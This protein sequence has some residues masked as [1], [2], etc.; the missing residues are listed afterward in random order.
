MKRIY[1]WSLLC[2]VVLWSGCQAPAG[3]PPALEQKAGVD[4]ISAHPNA[5]LYP[6]MIYSPP[7]PLEYRVELPRGAVAYLVPSNELPLISLKMIFREKGW[8]AERNEI[9]AYA[10]L[11]GLMRRGGA[12]SL[13]PSAVEDSLEQYAVSAGLSVGDHSSSLTLD[14]LDDVFEQF[15][16]L[17]QS[18]ALTPRLDSTELEQMRTRSLQAIAHRYDRPATASSDLY[19]AVMYGVSSPAIWSAESEEVTRVTRKEIAQLALNR[20]RPEQLVIGVAGRFDRTAMVELLSRWIEQWPVQE[21]AV[22]ELSLPAPRLYPGVHLLDFDSEQA[23]I[24]MGQPFIQR[25]HPDYYASSIA[26]YILGSGGFT[27]RL[28]AAVRSREGLAYSVGSFVESSY[29]NPVTS[30]VSLQTKVES[31]GDAI[32]LIFEEIRRLTEEGPTPEELTKAVEGLIGSLPSLF[33]SPE[34][35]AYALL[36]N[37]LWQRSL[38]HYTEYPQRLREVT[39]D[40]VRR[41][42]K[43]YFAPEKMAV[44]IVGP[45]DRIRP[46]L[47]KSKIKESLREK[48]WS[49]ND[50]RQHKE[51]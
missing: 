12:G 47:Q 16:P 10:L 22:R 32:A 8:S 30:G 49:L 37:E 26:S 35:T 36:I 45:A 39:A 6:E 9:A 25:P 14:A 38:H 1:R 20:F 13:S 11:G 31:S 34:N 21:G 19:T 28:T 24:R 4:R 7:D 18:M 43:S 46:A 27:S 33:D 3:R 17:L 50:L 42:L 29:N 44:T 40:D 51:P 2:G 15:L 41:V 5:L 23:Q 48:E